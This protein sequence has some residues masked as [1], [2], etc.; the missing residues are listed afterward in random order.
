MFYASVFMQDLSG[1]CIEEAFNCFGVGDDYQHPTY[2]D[3]GGWRAWS[4]QT[5]DALI[6]FGEDRLL[7]I[8]PEP[9]GTCASISQI[10]M[11]NDDF[12]SVFYEID[13]MHDDNIYNIEMHIKLDKYG[14]ID[15]T[16]IIRRCND[17][18]EYLNYDMFES[19]E[20]FQ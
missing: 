7:L 8:S 4:W 16:N 11:L 9:D 1:S 6:G 20:I 5:N 17:K 14:N 19:M 2:E 12:I 3:Y 18:F 15:E 10:G 13:N